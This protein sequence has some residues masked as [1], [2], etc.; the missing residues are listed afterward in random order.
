MEIDQINTA[1]LTKLQKQ[2]EQIAGKHL[3]LSVEKLINFIFPVASHDYQDGE[4]TFQHIFLPGK[5]YIE[6][7]PVR[8]SGQF[9]DC[10]RRQ[11]RI[12]VERFHLHAELIRRAGEPGG[13]DAL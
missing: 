5:S 13:D 9:V 8:C 6:H 11:A 2:L 12:P 7:A 3:D 1:Q 4:V 10:R